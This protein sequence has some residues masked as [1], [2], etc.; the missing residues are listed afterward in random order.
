MPRPAPVTRATLPWSRFIAKP[1]HLLPLH[2]GSPRCVAASACRFH[3]I[4]NSRQFRSFR[5]SGADA[6]TLDL[7]HDAS[8][9]ALDETLLP[10][11]RRH[12]TGHGCGREGETA[13]AFMSVG[14]GPRHRASCPR[15]RP[16]AARPN[17]LFISI[18]DLNDWIE[19]FNDPARG[20]PEIAGPNLRE[21][22]NRGVAFTNAHTPVAA[23]QAHES[24]HHD[25]GLS[26]EQPL[27]H[28]A[29][30]QRHARIHRNHDPDPALPA[31]RLPDARSRQD[32]SPPEPAGA[33]LGRVRTA[34]NAHRTR[35][36]TRQC[37]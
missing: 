31:P 20:K 36:E 29:L 37:S 15:C 16:K 17:V 10:W 34:S 30:P 4:A 28:Q 14:A 35:R 27:D 26:E 2:L 5:P 13:A 12:G 8:R 9:T 3:T 1:S 11:R 18:D 32:L 23:L 25:R 7:T 33:S 24:E 21:L 22:A 19:P 6:A